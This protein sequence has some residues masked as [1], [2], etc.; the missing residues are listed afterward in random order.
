MSADNRTITTN[1]ANLLTQAELT[2][3]RNANK[4]MGE[5]YLP[6]P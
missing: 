5:G 4:G 6:S 2:A 3:Y 1:D